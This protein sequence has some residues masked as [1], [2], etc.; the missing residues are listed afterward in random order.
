MG[1]LNAL[2]RL[3]GVALVAIWLPL[4]LGGMKSLRTRGRFG[5]SEELIVTGPYAR[6]RHPLYAGLSMSTVGMGLILGSRRLVF[7]G[8][9]WLVVTWLWS[10]HEEVDLA[11]K[12]GPAYEVYRRETPA[13]IPRV[14]QL[15]RAWR[16]SS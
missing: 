10:I 14:G 15:L 13:M 12:F 6:V 1:R 5:E 11:E 9:V 16:H 4:L 3:L 7:G 2:G 8:S